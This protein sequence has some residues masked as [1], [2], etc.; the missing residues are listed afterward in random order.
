MAAAS[1][2][3]LQIAG[4][5][6]FFVARTVALSELT[7]KIGGCVFHKVSLIF[8]QKLKERVASVSQNFLVRNGCLLIS[9]FCVAL[10]VS[11]QP[12]TLSFYLGV[13]ASWTM[14]L[15]IN[16]A[17][18]G[19]SNYALSGSSSTPPP[20][21]RC[22]KMY[23]T[24]AMEN[25]L[26]PLR[27]PVDQ[28]QFQTAEETVTES[29]RISATTLLRALKTIECTHGDHAS[30]I[31]RARGRNL[32]TQKMPESSFPGCSCV[33]LPADDYCLYTANPRHNVTEGKEPD[34]SGAEGRVHNLYMYHVLLQVICSERGLSGLCVSPAMLYKKPDHVALLA[35]RS[36]S[37]GGQSP[38][39]GRPPHKFISSQALAW[40]LIDL[41]LYCYRHDLSL[42]CDCSVIGRD[43]RRPGGK[44]RLV[45][46]PG[47][48]RPRREGD[49][50]SILFGSSDPLGSSDPQ[51]SGD[52][53]AVGSS[54]FVGGNGLI[55][56]LSNP[57]L[58]I[59]QKD[60]YD[61]VATSLQKALQD[62][63]ITPGELNQAIQTQQEYARQSLI[64][65]QEQ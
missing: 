18:S 56:L 24:E 22:L 15:L 55:G 13:A 4:Q 60:K 10:V 43:F 31:M 35:A 11:P 17:F 5:T 20:S 23:G 14:V 29:S 50:R 64:S 57:K 52:D 49:L 21:S 1:T 33:F 36:L 38:S 42:Y 19:S 16:Y 37:S 3:L 47:S 45:L 32:E 41:V 7:H 63:E 54:S 2:G 30:T 12:L 39:A 28:N 9:V 25:F 61:V 46:T 34:Y 59:N 62:A 65:N 6:V 27:M 58:L 8:P 40:Q 51:N 44:P 53:G 26:K 48:L